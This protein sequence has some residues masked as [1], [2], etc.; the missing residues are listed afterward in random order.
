M[1]NVLIVHLQRIVFSF[2]TFMNDKINSRFEFPQ[3]MDLKDYSFKNQ[4][5]DNKEKELEHLA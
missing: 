1:P 5:P 4:A 3:V 2:D